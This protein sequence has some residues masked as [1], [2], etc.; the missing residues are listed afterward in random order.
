MVRLPTPCL[1]AALILLSMFAPTPAQAEGSRFTI[2]DAR[3]GLT[4][5]VLDAYADAVKGNTNSP[6][7]KSRI[8]LHV[9]GQH[10]FDAP[11]IE[12]EHRKQSVDVDIDV[13]IA[14]GQTLRAPLHVNRMIFDRNKAP[15]QI[16][17]STQIR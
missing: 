2:I 14:G 8:I 9:S 13:R 6:L 17:Q 15:T 4:P 5:E 16:R 7:T 10:G 3:D 1:Y 11:A 12:F